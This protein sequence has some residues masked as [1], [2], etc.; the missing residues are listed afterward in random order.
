MK[1][2][3]ISFGVILAM[4][5]MALSMV[6]AAC[7]P[8]GGDD[9]GSSDADAFNLISGNRAAVICVEGTN[10]IGSTDGDYPG[11]VRAAYDLQSDVELITGVKP[12]VTKELKGYTDYA[13]IIGTVGKSSA[14]AEIAENGKIDTS[15]IEG[16][17]E[18]YLVQTVQDPFNDGTVGTALV[19]AGS[20][21]RGSIY[22]IY[23]VSE[24]LGMTP[25]N[26]FADS[27]PAQKDNLVL[28]GDYRYVSREPS[29]KYRGIFINDEECL[30]DWARSLDEGKNL[31]PNFYEK[32]FECLLRMK[33]N[34]L[35][36]GM[37][38]CSD[39]F[40]DYM[41]NPVNA[42][43]YGIVIG[44]SHCDMLLR[45][46]LNEWDTFLSE[47]KAE[48]P[49]YAGVDIEYDYTLFPE[50][51]QDYW[52]GSVRENKDYEVQWTLGIRGP[53]DDPLECADIDK[54]PWYGDKNLLMETVI[55]DQRQ[56]LR[57][58]LDNPT[59]EDVFMMFIPY[60]E[61]Q[62]I[63]NNGLEVPDDV[64][65]MWVDDNHGFIRDVPNEVERQ[66]SG[67]HGV[68]YHNSY[69]GPDNESYM[70]VNSMPLT[71]MYEELNKAYDNGIQTAWVLNPGDTI[72]YM[73]EIGFVMDLGYDIE[74][75]NNENVFETYVSQ[76]AAREFG[77]EFSEDLTQIVRE[78]TQMTN[79]RKL[80]QMSVDIFTDA[81]GDEMERRAAQY[82]DLWERAEA[83]YDAIPARQRDCFYELFLF[84]IRCA[85]FTN[86]EFYYAQ[87]GNVAYAQ[88]RNATAWNCFMKSKEFNEKRKDEISYYNVV[89]Q[90]G[91]WNHLVDPEVYHSPA[92]AGFASGS[93]TFTLGETEM[94]V[95]AEGEQAETQNSVL[96][97]GNYAQGRKYVDVFN[98]GEGSF[99]FQVS[100]DSDFILVS[101]TEDVVTDEVRLWISID[102]DKVSASDSG[103]VSIS[104][105][106]QTK[107]ITVNVQKDDYQLGEKTYVEQDG[108]VS[109]EAEHYS[110]SRETDTTY[111][112][113][114]K[115]LGRVSGDMVTAYTETL[116]GYGES[117]FESQAPYLEYNVYFANT[118]SFE[119]EIYRLPSLR[120]RDRIRFAVSVNNETPIVVEG[121]N[122]YGTNNPAW[123]EG[124]FTQIIKHQVT[125]DI[126]NAGLNTIRIYMIDPYI[127]I[128][129]LVVYTSEK[130]D[131]YFGP[132]ESYNTTYNTAPADKAYYES[133]YES[134][135]ELPEGYDIGRGYGTGAFI[136]QNGKLAIEAEAAEIGT[137]E[138]GAWKEGR[139][140]V[141]QTDAGIS[142]RTEDLRVD[143]D[144]R[145][146]TE[147]PTLNY[148]IVVN[149]PGTYRVW[150]NINNPS[151]RSSCYAVGLDGRYQFVIAD[152]N[153]S[154]EEVFQWRQGSTVN[155]TAG[156]H[157]F[158]VYC[159]QDGVAIDKIYLSRTS[160]TPNNNTFVQTARTPI[161]GDAQAQIRD[162]ALR[163]SLSSAVNAIG[164]YYNV[165]TGDGLGE[166]GET[167]YAALM[168]AIDNA[169][170]LIDSADALEDAQVTQALDDLEN[171]LTALYASRNMTDGD[172]EYLLYECFDKAYMGLE[173]FGF[174]YHTKYLTPDVSV[175]EGEDGK[176]F[177]IRTFKEQ[178]NQETAFVQYAFAAQSGIFTMEARASF[179][180]GEWG[181][182]YLLNENGDNAIC[183][184]FEFAD[185][186]YNLVAYNGNVK[187]VIGH[188][189]RN[190][191]VDIKV[192]ADVAENTFDVYVG[193]ELV[194]EGLAFRM[195]TQSVGT[196]MFGS[197]SRNADFRLYEMKIYGE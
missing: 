181:S 125:L 77:A 95:I 106:G 67:G 52:R 59:L 62:A 90:D 17:W 178:A 180:E 124:V 151:P 165:V 12:V 194:A 131:S 93:P 66:R 101:E 158:T 23:S 55:E 72:P 86:A 134:T 197:S 13:V 121:E 25:W 2:K 168:G 162:A 109:I 184:A 56:I 123:E 157:T 127:T 120:S 47:Y 76:V 54:A 64:T 112:S 84:E 113:V 51:L 43:Y 145:W 174:T 177:N 107:T 196:V 60:K 135:Y 154:R 103:T 28:A 99:E 142:M 82:K 5:V 161:D 167:E 186:A 73:F 41:E 48:H 110:A 156:V 20:D 7:A 192:V 140:L 18:C 137:E 108:Y 33:S 188:Y 58:E 46:N 128:D 6:F 27:V 42:D 24:M 148:T 4:I 61:V 102:W 34:Y 176:Y 153:W 36:P 138:T 92:M 117:N 144:G 35:W 15:S 39:A 170:A 185:N 30:V 45:N 133:Y 1:K 26:F 183:I 78:Y 164:N 116:V 53:H 37:H 141:A 94:G 98:K 122:D 114:I 115:D 22:G 118:G 169:Y 147:A 57:E 160:E 159:S 190:V 100:V 193:G 63:Y 31:G 83:M 81:Y 71:L 129:K 195:S 191:A 136:E 91:K 10:A 3:R 44:T 173:P 175:A 74:K 14:I 143:Y 87:K 139:W 68:Y 111:W 150:V 49:E 166:Y 146:E 182:L 171:A 96:S 105:N 65:I 8:S 40:S 19:I 69:W 97:F 89:L 32:L 163:A 152:F 130:L 38:A 75:Y 50:V 80:E 70:W 172:R 104:A 126:K 85:Y 16:K 189:E 88:G 29:V 119:T 11:V 155:L 149:T 187:T 179:N 132:L 21:K 9:N 79:A